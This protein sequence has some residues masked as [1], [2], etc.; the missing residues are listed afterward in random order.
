MK[1]LY[2]F[3][4]QYLSDPSIIAISELG[5]WCAVCDDACTLRLPVLIRVVSAAI[6]SITYYSSN[7]EFR[8]FE[9]LLLR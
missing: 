7:Y 4:W 3:P 1:S 2:F 9:Q 5:Q 8:A 6:L